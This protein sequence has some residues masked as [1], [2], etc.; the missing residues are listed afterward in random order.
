M[1][2][3]GLVQAVSRTYTAIAFVLTVYCGLMTI[4]VERYLYRRRG[5]KREATITA[6]IG[7]TYVGGGVLLYVTLLVLN[8][9]L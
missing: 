8:E 5:Y 9:I 7:W 4:M 1:G 2:L 3:K 6:W